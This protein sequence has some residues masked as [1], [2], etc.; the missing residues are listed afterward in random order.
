MPQLVQRPATE[1]GQRFF[2]RVRVGQASGGLLEDLGRA[3]VRRSGAVGDR[4]QVQRGDAAWIRRRLLTWGATRDEITR[5]WSG[6][7]LIPDSN[8][9]DCTM[10]TTLPA[11]PDQVWPWLVQMSVGR[12]GWYSWDRLDNGGK[13][14]AD[15]IVP[16]WQDLEVG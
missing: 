4:A 11:P 2:R 5:A 6:D 1:T 13:P 10:A 16:E 7:E 8:T 14:S 3:A 15:R 9:P 12:A